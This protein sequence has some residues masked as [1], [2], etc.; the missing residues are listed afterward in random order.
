VGVGPGAPDLLT[1]RAAHVLAGVDVL[2]AAC[3]PRNDYSAA[4]DTALPHVRPGTEIVRLAFPMTRQGDM[5][6]RAWD[7]AARRSLA[8]LES[9]KSAAFLT[10]GDPLIYSTFGY[11][12]REIRKKSPDQPVEIVPGITSFQA[13]AARACLPLCEGEQSLR[14]LSGI[15]NAETLERDLTGA[16]TA[17]ILKAYRNIGAI[18]QALRA[19]GRDADCLVAG[20]VELPDERL[21]TLGKLNRQGEQERNPASDRATPPYMTLILSPAPSSS[22]CSSRDTPSDARLD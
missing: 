15:N 6:R 2:L 16:D 17:V 8:V 18:A 13:A 21:T 14:V 20:R 10:I 4:L 1:L 9:G 3:S 11:L 19:T 5:L 12:L 22:I 7:E